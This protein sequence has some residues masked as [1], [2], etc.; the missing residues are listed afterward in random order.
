MKCGFG[1]CFYI[2]ILLVKRDIV[3]YWVFGKLFLFF[4]SMF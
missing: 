4:D 1:G 3:E 2:I